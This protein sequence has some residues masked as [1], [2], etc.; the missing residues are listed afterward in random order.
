MAGRRNPYLRSWLRCGVNEHECH[1]FR[2]LGEA[3]NDRLQL[4]RNR[5]LTILSKL[6]L[7]GRILPEFYHIC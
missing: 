5:D 1:V 7:T 3:G 6:T 2:V 4:H